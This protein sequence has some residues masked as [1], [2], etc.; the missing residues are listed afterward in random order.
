MANMLRWAASAAVFFLLIA[1]CPYNAR[2]E[3]AEPANGDAAVGAMLAMNTGPISL[4]IAIY[5]AK[6][7]ADTVWLANKDRI[8]GTIISMSDGKLTIKTD[9]AGELV[10]DWKK[11]AGIDS[12]KPLVLDLGD[13]G[14]IKGKVEEGKRG[15]VTVDG[16][17][18][19]LSRVTAINP[20]DKSKLKLSGGVHLSMANQHGNTSKN[21]YD[22]DGRVT[23][24]WGD[25]RAILGY[26]GH[27]ED[28][29]GEETAN[30]DLA[31]L[32]Y[33]RFIDQNWYGLGNLRVSHDRLA[34][35]NFRSALGGGLG[36]QVWRD[37]K[38]NLSV[39]FGPNYVYTDY[40]DR[41]DPYD[42]FAAR[43]AL[44]FDYWLFG[45]FS[46]FFHRHE[47]FV[48]ADDADNYFFTTRTG[49]SFPIKGGF[50]ANLQYNYDWNNRPASD[51][52]KEDSKLMLLFGYDW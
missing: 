38:K 47:I 2:A 3:A 27:H 19:E 26:E 39:E 23:G 29:Q 31:Y 28:S 21:N 8:S 9:Y 37:S 6:A 1:V 7:E 11:V 13:E 18:V 51:K 46:K 44:D 15:R 5:P 40:S 33:N 42:W 24:T 34:D 50:T 35:I 32:E 49:F 52:E 48:Q 43:W 17:E 36:Y 22:L 41:D 4:K 14:Q 12:V 25:N 30:N 16:K 45:K 10:I 20:E